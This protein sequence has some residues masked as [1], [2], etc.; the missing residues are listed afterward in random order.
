[1]GSVPGS[2]RFPGGGHGKPLQ[3]SCLENP[4]DRGEW[5]ATQ[6]MVSQRVGHNRVTNILDSS[7]CSV[8]QSCLTLCDPMDYSMPDFPVLH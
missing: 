7:C 2:G 1:M 3:Y 4:K 6:S 5:W 8:T